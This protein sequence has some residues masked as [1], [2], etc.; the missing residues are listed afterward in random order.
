MQRYVD[1]A[2]DAV[3]AL[4]A[5]HENGVLKGQPLDAVIATYV[6][7]PP[8]SDNPF[9]P[10]L[11]SLINKV[12]LVSNN[13]GVSRQALVAALLLIDEDHQQHHADATLSFSL[14]WDH[15]GDQPWLVS[16]YVRIKGN[17]MTTDQAN[18]VIT[19]IVA[20]I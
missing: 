13:Q 16:Q 17:G 12:N 2:K 1:V 9:S 18:A 14:I 19:G 10:E 4:S 7:R 11:L 20:N 3:L 6:L 15:V 5:H 8:D